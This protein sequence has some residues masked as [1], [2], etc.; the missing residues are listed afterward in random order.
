MIKKC[1]TEIGVA[2][3]YHRRKRKTIIKALMALKQSSS[4]AGKIPS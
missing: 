4:P 2:F 3:F 1:H